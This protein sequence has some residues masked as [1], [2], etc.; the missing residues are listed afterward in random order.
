[1]GKLYLLPTEE[2]KKRKRRK[3]VWKYVAFSLAAVIIIQN[4]IMFMM[5]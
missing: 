2:I 5:T 4:F 1:M 3:I